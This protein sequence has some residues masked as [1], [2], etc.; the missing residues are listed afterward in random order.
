VKALERGLKRTAIRALGSLSSGCKK[1]IS[2]I[3]TDSVK[4]I[5]LVKQHDQLGD[6]L[7][8]SPVIPAV[9]KKFP[10]ARLMVC[11]RGYTRSVLTGDPL[12]DDVLV[13]HER[14][15]GW[16]IKDMLCIVRCFLFA[17]DLAVVFNT[18]SRSLTS[19]AIALL[20]R[21]KYRVGPAEPRYPGV[22]GNPFYNVEVC[23]PR[24]R[25]HMSERY[26]SIVELLGVS[27]L[28]ANERMHLAPEWEEDAENI[29]AGWGIGRNDSLFAMHP[30]GARD[31]TRWPMEKYAALGDRLSSLPNA[32]VIVVVGRNESWGY[33]VAELMKVKPTICSVKELKLLAA[34]F[35]RVR[36]YVGND[37]GLLHVAAAV[38]T[39][40]VGIYGKTEPEIWKPKGSH[41]VAVTSKDN[42]I[43]SVEVE[44]VYDVV[45]RLLQ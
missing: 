19:D 13:I 16:R 40:A 38:G 37:T 30:G 32:K 3:R 39:K 26:L 44:A 43:S 1:N 17:S 5:M 45:L 10:K 8:F 35:K 12:V 20:S 42:K 25:V 11:T 9:R 24:E 4:R 23:V 27:A 6:L 21:A 14:L 31:Y 29:L 36:L 41:V 28:E 22:N 34:I 15:S 33:K 18:I 7:L 2:E